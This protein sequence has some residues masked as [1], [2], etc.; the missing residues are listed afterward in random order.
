M[1]QQ[2]QDSFGAR[3]LQQ[4]V[5]KK[6]LRPRVAASLIAGLWLVTIVVFGII[7]HLLDPDSF[8]TVWQ[9]MWWATQTVTT[10]GYGDVVPGDP[11]GRFVATILMIG[12]LSLFAVVTGTITSAFVT[13]AQEMN[14]DAAEEPL[15]DKL[16]AL[17]AEVA[18]LREQLSDKD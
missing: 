7:E 13:R 18:A 2:P 12:G 10:V 8:N 1:E 17:T 9:G 11:I 15:E 14:R 16:D 4:R 3:L 5:A 6:G